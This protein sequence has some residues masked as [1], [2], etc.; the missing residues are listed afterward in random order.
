M[1][2]ILV[3]FLALVIWAGIIFAAIGIFAALGGAALMF[4]R[5]VLPPLLLTATALTLRGAAAA[6]IITI[7]TIREMT[8]HAARGVA[9]WQD[10]PHWQQQAQERVRQEQ[11]VPIIDSWE[12]ACTLLGLP[13]GG[14]GKP[15]LSRAYRQA[16]VTAHP[17]VGG[18]PALAKALNVARDLIRQQQGWA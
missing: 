8:G 15:E 10:Q 16:I 5:F 18:N 12:A 6:V 13:P 7:A 17:D 3:L 11:S 9:I 2:F 4:I 1:E 14:F